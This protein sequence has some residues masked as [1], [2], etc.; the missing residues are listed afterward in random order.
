M[1]TE[2]AE[3]RRF[4]VVIVPFAQRHFI[5]S[6]EKK[7]KRNWDITLD[8]LKAQYS[9]IESLVRNN[10]ISAPIHAS[11][12]NQ[13]WI[14]KHSFAVAGLDTSPRAS[15]NRAILSVDLAACTVYVLLVYH[16]TDIKDGDETA[17]WHALIKA[18]CEEY[19][20]AFSL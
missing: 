12:D 20:K 17:Q 1:S 13:H 2:A 9:H 14:L 15:G 4:K 11:P 7:Y 16:K 6:F 5:K 10:R 8:A 19:L 3:Q 18:H